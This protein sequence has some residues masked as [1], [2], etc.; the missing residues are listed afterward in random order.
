MGATLQVYRE[1]VEVAVSA[2][3]TSTRQPRS[4]GQRHGR[5]KQLPKA[6]S[7]QRPRFQLFRGTPVVRLGSCSVNSGGARAARCGTPHQ[8]EIRKVAPVTVGDSSQVDPEAHQNT[9]AKNK[10]N[11]PLRTLRNNQPHSGQRQRQDDTNNSESW[12][13]GVVH[14]VGRS[15]NLF[16]AFAARAHNHTHQLFFPIFFP[17]LLSSRRRR[18]F[19]HF[20]A[21]SSAGEVGSD[22]NWDGRS[23]VGQRGGERRTAL[24]RQENSTHTA[25]ALA[26]HA[27]R[28]LLP[29]WNAK[30]GTKNPHNADGPVRSAARAWVGR[31]ASL[32]LGRD[33]TA[34]QM[35]VV[36][37]AHSRRRSHSAAG[38]EQSVRRRPIRKERG[39]TKW[40]ERARGEREGGEKKTGCARSASW[41]LSAQLTFSCAVRLT[42]CWYA[43]L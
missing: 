31:S 36:P 30:Y 21:R 15:A 16:L 17:L 12:V 42:D 23:S 13:V 20:Q 6:P 10:N 37:G 2:V 9:R 26:R 1:T 29:A 38:Q 41:G 18:T 7:S 19:L 28:Q 3:R 11:R 32:P 24:R 34:D 27:R 5:A 4:S 8:R 22:R 25:S 40:R 14:G 35:P 43:S 39:K 33:V